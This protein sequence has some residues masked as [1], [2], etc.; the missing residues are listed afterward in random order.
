MSKQEDEKKDEKKT[1]VAFIFRIVWMKRNLKMKTNW[2]LWNQC[3]KWN[4][5]KQNEKCLDTTE[6]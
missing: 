5:E 2:M 3:T 6:N 4:E 1:V